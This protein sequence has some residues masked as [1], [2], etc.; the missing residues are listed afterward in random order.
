M[1]KYEDSK[2][3]K[4]SIW[5]KIWNYIHTRKI[6][7][8]KEFSE[9]DNQM[10]ALSNPIPHY[11]F[12]KKVKILNENYSKNNLENLPSLKTHLKTSLQPI[13]RKYYGNSFF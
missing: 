6:D 5:Q 2:M 13:N 3:F 7:M 11:E 4:E 12:S 8:N 1:K 10:E 9:I